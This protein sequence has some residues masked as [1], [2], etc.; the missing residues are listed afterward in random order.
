MYIFYSHLDYIYYIVYRKLY[1][2]VYYLYKLAVFL[3]IK[4]NYV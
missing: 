1:Q 3:H 2:L 4:K